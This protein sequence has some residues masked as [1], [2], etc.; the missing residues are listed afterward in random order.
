MRLQIVCR[1]RED[2]AWEAANELV[3]GV[4]DER[5]ARVHEHYSGSEANRRVQ[6]L[7]RTHGDTIE[8]NLWTGIT[9]VRPGAGIAIVGNPTQCADVIQRYIDLGCTSFCLSG[10]L[11]DEEATRFAEMVRPLL[12]ER[13]P[14]RMN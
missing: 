14:G 5:T 9:R 13:N 7:A 8:A 11:H 3:R 6:E 2:E 4:T 12:C 1:E 10:Y